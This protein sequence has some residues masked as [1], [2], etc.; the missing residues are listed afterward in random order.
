MET[1][2]AVMPGLAKAAWNSGP[3]A[4]IFSTLETIP[5]RVCPISIGFWIGPRA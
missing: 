1:L 2:S 5:S 4:W 3:Y